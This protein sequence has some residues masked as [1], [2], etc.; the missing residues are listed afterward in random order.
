MKSVRYMILVCRRW[1]DSMATRNSTLGIFQSSHTHHRRRTSNTVSSKSLIM[2][3]SSTTTDRQK[4]TTAMMPC[5]QILFKKN[6]STPRDRETQR[7]MQQQSP[8]EDEL[9][10]CLE[11]RLVWN[12]VEISISK[13]ASSIHAGEEIWENAVAP[14]F[15]LGG[16]GPTFYQ[17]PPK[18]NII[19]STWWEKTIQFRNKRKIGRQSLSLRQQHIF[20]KKHRLHPRNLT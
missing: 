15:C 4:K 7:H 16:G 18:Q 11:C 12:G 20:Q 3:F 5:M 1:V 9:L 17:K 10:Q 14:Y 19:I 2:I 6:A 13:P 8:L